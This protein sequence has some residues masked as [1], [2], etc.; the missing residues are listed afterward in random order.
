[1]VQLALALFAV[2]AAGLTAGENRLVPA[3]SGCT[4]AR[5]IDC[6]CDGYGVGSP[7]GPDADDQDSTVNTAASMLKKHGSVDAF[8]RSKGLNFERIIYVS[9]RDPSTKGSRHEPGL[10][11]EWEEAQKQVRPGDCV[12]FRGSTSP[13]AQTYAG[14]GFREKGGTAAK[15]ITIMAYP[16]ERVALLESYSCIGLFRTGNLVFDGFTCFWKGP[17]GRSGVEMHFVHD[18]T[19][20]NIETFGHKWGIFGAQDWKNIFVEN[21]VVHDNSPEHGI[22]IGARDLPNSRVTIRN[23]LIY[24]N[25]RHGIQSN[26][27]CRELVLE[28]NVIHS[29]ALGGISLINGVQNSSITRNLIYN[30][31]KQGIILYVYRE[32][33]GI[34][35]Y[36]NSDNFFEGNV[37]WI[38]KNNCGL[39][40]DRPESQPAV[41][42]NDAS[43]GSEHTM[44]G[45]V[46]RN[47][48]FVTHG[49]AIFQFD[50]PAHIGATTVTDNQFYRRAGRGRKD[51]CL[52]S[53]PSLDGYVGD[54]SSC[55]GVPFLQKQGMTATG[56]K[57]KNP[58][59][60]A[61]AIEFNEIPD[62]FDFR[63]P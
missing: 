34:L 57:N 30:N 41:L 13:P 49:G 36:A 61:A 11:R 7:A 4:T 62:D 6:D 31:N 20:R 33:N 3:G 42:F 48:T 59:F 53:V 18:V 19:L 52:V 2:F 10:F 56:N 50:Q 16:G 24:R 26:G 12:L 54:G 58:G 44:T 51:D 27:R 25:G 15:Q 22:Y 63:R 45:N 32:G 46:F 55:W 38:G 35:P 1:M 39:G 40:R 5:Y 21:S 37:I 17:E 43:P 60:R 14:V 47:N 23:C 8:L 29:N 28:R 9:K